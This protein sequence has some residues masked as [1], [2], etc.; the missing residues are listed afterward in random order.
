MRLNTPTEPPPPIWDDS[1]QD[2]LLE[3]QLTQSIQDARATHLPREFSRPAP[4]KQITERI[5]P[6]TPYANL[7]AGCGIAAIDGY[8][9]ARDYAASKGLDLVE[10]HHK[11]IDLQDLISTLVIHSQKAAEIE[12]RQQPAA[13]YKR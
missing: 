12:S 4:I 10:L 5:Q 13:R 9:A 1:F 2:S 8:L 6:N 7:I 3:A 11:G